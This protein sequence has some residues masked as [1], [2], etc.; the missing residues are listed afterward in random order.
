M[1]KT[2]NRI[3]AILIIIWIIGSF[4]GFVFAMQSDGSRWLGLVLIGQLL[5]VAGIAVTVSLIQDKQKSAPIGGLFIFVGG[6]LFV[7]GFLS[8]FGSEKAQHALMNL[9]PAILG[10]LFLLIGI[11]GLTASI[12]WK[13]RKEK[14]YTT[15]VDAVCIARRQM[16]GGRHVLTDPVY[17]ITWKDNVYELDNC[18]YRS[19]SAPEVGETRTLF[20]DE[21]DVGSYLDPA[22]A[23][24][25][26][27]AG[28]LKSVFF[29][30]FVIVGGIVLILFFSG[31][32]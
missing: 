17:R 24:A 32:F 23:G 30:L 9:F 10:G 26:R 27:I 4:V 28:I 13:K 21:N 29:S 16:Q 8:R 14:K 5:F 31:R 18:V 7:G 11:C 12:V 1:K 2:G 22:E 6:I 19:G 3:I 15:P 20:I 25:E